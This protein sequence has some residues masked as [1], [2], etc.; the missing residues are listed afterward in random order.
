MKIRPLEGE[1]LHADRQTKTDGR[2]DMTKLIVPF[3]NS[4]NASKNAAYSAPTYVLQSLR[5]LEISE[6]NGEAYLCYVH[7]K[8]E[9]SGGGGAIRE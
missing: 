8:V 7:L 2:T 1:L 5:A 9:K 3:R 6:E 4:A